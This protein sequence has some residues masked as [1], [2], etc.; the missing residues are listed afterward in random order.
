MVYIERHIKL[1]LFLMI[2]SL[3]MAQQDLLSHK[4]NDFTNDCVVC[5]MVDHN[6]VLTFFITSLVII[7]V[8][9]GTVF[10]KCRIILLQP[11]HWITPALRAP[12][13]FLK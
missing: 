9:L 10:L 12:P 7:F 6:S 4:H 5:H 2:A 13:K 1:L 8:A 11:K 3:L